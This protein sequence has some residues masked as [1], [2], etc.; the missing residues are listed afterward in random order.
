[1]R[2]LTGWKKYAVWAA[3]GV[4]ALVASGAVVWRVLGPAEV[5][6]TAGSAYPSPVATPEP[7]ALGALVNSP[8]IIDGSLRVYAAKRQ[9]Q[10]DDQP[11]Y[12]YETSPFWSYRRWPQQ[13]IGVVHPP[14]AATAGI[15]VVVGSWSD[16]KLIA[17]DARTGQVAWE[18]DGAV[19]GTE[20]P[21]RRT[22]SAVVWTP[23]GLLTG[24]TKDG[25]AVVV[26]VKDGITVTDAASGTRLWTSAEAGCAALA[27]TVPGEIVV[28]DRC[29]DPSRLRRLDL[30]TGT[31]TEPPLELSKTVTPLG[32]RVGRSECG[33]V[34]TRGVAWIWSDGTPKPAAGLMG[35]TAWLAGTTAIDAPLGDTAET[36]ALTGKDPLTGEVRWTWSS[37]GEDV[38]EAQ[39]IAGT[40]DRVLL[41]TR[42]RTLIAVDAATGK[43]LT[44]VSV[45]MDHDP[46]QQYAVGPVYASGAFV[47]IERL[48]LAYTQAETDDEYYYTNR[49]V[50]LAAG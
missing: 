48:S 7:G 6:T 40:Q 15:P 46:K 2:R 43:E 3:L 20:Y 47:A 5:V 1:M 39:V 19:L 34:R 50:L 18:A 26:T 45:I 49:P 25:K 4:V 31:P 41:L 12:R 11:A 21:G 35:A 38:S 10:A 29:D 22:G 28:A 24:V 27:F 14:T 23:T 9:I 37:T 16:G 33:G 44:R 13:L 36:R 42:A 17:I 30:N 8:L 32:C